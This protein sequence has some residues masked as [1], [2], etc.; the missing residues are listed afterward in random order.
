[1][2]SAFSQADA[3][4]TLEAGSSFLQGSTSHTLA[5]SWRGGVLSGSLEEFCSLS[6][7]LIAEGAQDFCFCLGYLLE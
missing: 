7:P 2:F 4:W 6:A 3:A 5:T 1:M